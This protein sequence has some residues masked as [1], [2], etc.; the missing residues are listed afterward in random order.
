[1]GKRVLLV[2]QKMKET[3]IKYPRQYK[4]IVKKGL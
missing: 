1:M 4:Q 2:F 3:D